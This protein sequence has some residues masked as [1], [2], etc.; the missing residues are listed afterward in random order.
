MASTATAPGT[1]GEPPAGAASS[2]PAADR[3][4]D[5][6]GAARESGPPPPWLHTLQSLWRDLPGLVSDRVELLSLELRRAGL[7]L[8]QMVMLVVAVAI[9]GVTAWLVLWA[10][11]VALLMALGLHV[12]WALLIVLAI[13]LGAIVLAALR[14][15]ALLP[16]M[17]LS[18]T[19][20]HL[21]PGP[22]A[23]SSST[24]SSERA[25]DDRHQHRP[26]DFGTA[27]QPAAR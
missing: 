7:A 3:G 6:S 14:V 18:A 22:P 15:R 1:P 17:N 21:V 20:R 13:N 2:G 27:G 9:L 8:V 11:V 10:G 24:P 25:H 4:A 23:S 5:P 16:R 26:A 19:R 12:G